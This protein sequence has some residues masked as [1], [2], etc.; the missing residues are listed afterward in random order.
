VPGPGLI[1][2]GEPRRAK[3][4]TSLEPRL[5]VNAPEEVLDVP[6]LQ[7]RS[8]CPTE[9]E[10]RFELSVLRLAELIPLTPQRGDG[11]GERGATLRGLL[12]A[13]PE[14]PPSNDLLLR[15]PA[16]VACPLLSPRAPSPHRSDRSPLTAPVALKRPRVALGLAALIPSGGDMAPGADPSGS[17]AAFSGSLV[18]A[19]ALGGEA[20]ATRGDRL[21]ED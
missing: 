9:V 16:V 20:E 15:N 11:E 19:R 5:A 4:G 1:A 12:A 8:P 17:E 2:S 10:R 7:A 18:L 21:G 3:S 6:L 14:L 13:A